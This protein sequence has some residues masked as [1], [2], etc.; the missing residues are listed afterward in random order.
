M[1]ELAVRGSQNLKH[2]GVFSS[3]GNPQSP[4]FTP[5][6]TLLQLLPWHLQLHTL[7]IPEL[8]N[9]RSG[10][11][12]A[13]CQLDQNE[14]FITLNNHWGAEVKNSSRSTAMLR[15]FWRPF[16]S[17]ATL[18]LYRDRL[19]VSANQSGKEETLGKVTV[20]KLFWHFFGRS[21]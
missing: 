19:L 17:C 12:T 1:N 20:E 15:N 9:H 7:A 18:A 4:T 21:S 10:S 11:T 13:S 8:P 5:L 16:I 3:T 6:I 2:S 14:I